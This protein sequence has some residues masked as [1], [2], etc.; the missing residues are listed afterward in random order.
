MA[1]SQ[2]HYKRGDNEQRDASALELEDPA[3]AVGAAK[4]GHA[5]FEQVERANEWG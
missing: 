5:G 3:G 4:R 2:E 1:A